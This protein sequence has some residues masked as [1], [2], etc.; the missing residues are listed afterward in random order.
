MKMKLIHNEFPQI[1]YFQNE[2]KDCIFK[3]SI[4]TQ[5][6]FHDMRKQVTFTIDSQH[7]SENYRGNTRTFFVVSVIKK[8]KSKILP[9]LSEKE[10]EG[11]DESNAELVG[12]AVAPVGQLI[13]PGLLLFLCSV[14]NFCSL[15]PPLHK[16]ILY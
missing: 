2:D 1:V 10:E 12:W 16:R 7:I 5:R 6:A 14:S 15:N 11:L 4:G 13:R 8:K 9:I 3:S